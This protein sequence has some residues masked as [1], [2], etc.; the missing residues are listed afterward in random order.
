MGALDMSI[1]PLHV[2]FTLHERGVQI[3]TGKLST[4]GHYLRGHSMKLTTQ[5][6][7]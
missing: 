1:L 4:N 6:L 3:M 5:T 2:A 7:P